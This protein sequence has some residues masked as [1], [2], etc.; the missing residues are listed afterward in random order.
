MERKTSGVA[1]WGLSAVLLAACGMARAQAP[2]PPRPSVAAGAKAA[3]V[4]D[5]PGKA[6]GQLVEQLERHPARPSTAADRVRGI[7]PAQSRHGPGRP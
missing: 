3:D 6:A 4:A 7:V 5:G 2:D 1:L